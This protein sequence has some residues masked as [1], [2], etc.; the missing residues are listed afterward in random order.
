MDKETVLFQKKESMAVITLNRPDSKN[1]IN[2]QMVAELE[3]IRNEI[4]SDN[5]IR[6]VI[7]TGKETFCT[8][9]DAE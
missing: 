4:S 9:T 6:V 2:T 5:D 3:Y 1:A 7:I 8:G